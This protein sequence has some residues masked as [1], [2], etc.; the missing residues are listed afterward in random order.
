MADLTLQ[1]EVAKVFEEL[2]GIKASLAA[3]PNDGIKK[4][5]LE[6]VV[7][8]F[9]AKFAV[10]E[11][12]KRVAALLPI[13]DEEVKIKPYDMHKFLRMVKNGDHA[14]MAREFKTITE[15]TEGAAVVPTM[16]LPKIIETMLN[17]SIVAGKCTPLSMATNKTDIPNISTDVSVAFVAEAGG[18]TLQ[19]PVLGKITP[20]LGKIVAALL[21]TQE[22]LQDE[23][24]DM[25]PFWQN[26]IGL[27]AGQALDAAILENT[28]GGDL[29]GGIKTI[30]GTNS[31]TFTKPVTDEDI[32]DLQNSQTVEAYHQNAAWYFNRA[33]LGILMKLKNDDGNTLFGSLVNGVPTS[34]LGKSFFL[35]D[36]I[37][38]A[39]TTA[40]KTS[41]YYADMA[42]AWLLSHSKY[43]NMTVEMSNS[44]VAPN[45]TPTINAFLQSL[46]GFRFNLR[47]GFIIAVPA[48]FT[49]GLNVYK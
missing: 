24:I 9:T 27:K 30:T 40:S 8:D 10:L 6:K 47:K 45:P 20:Q 38:G 2:Q 16:F 36:Q 21:V 41:I 13:K 5:E 7:A 31:T 35:T 19:T 29:P 4:A 32:I 43:P 18:V 26:R 42:N 34:L 46:L 11:E 44:V 12:Q 17:S 49:R 15:A 37:A 22:Q 3:M 23:Q 1:E 48:A 25:T 14:G 33:C 39:G 28:A